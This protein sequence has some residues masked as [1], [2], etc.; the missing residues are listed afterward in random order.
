MPTSTLPWVATLLLAGAVRTAS[1]QELQLSACDSGSP[2]TAGGGASV[3]ANTGD[4]KQG[5]ASFQI[6]LAQ[7]PANGPYVRIGATAPWASY[8]GV[9]FWVKRVS[10]SDQ[11]AALQLLWTRH[12]A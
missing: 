3:S 6:T 12:Y 11:G 2:A 4:K 7:T 10:G 5:D 1:A 8:S 9:R